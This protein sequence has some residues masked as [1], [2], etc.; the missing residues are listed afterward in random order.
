[1]IQAA[2]ACNKLDNLDSIPEMKN[3]LEE[4]SQTGGDLSFLRAIHVSGSKGKGSVCAFTENILKFKGLRTGMFTSPHL[5]HPRERIRVDGKPVCENVFAKHVLRLDSEMKAKG[6]GQISFFRFLWILAVDIFRE[7]GVEVGIIEVGMG[8]RF[9]ATNVIAHP[10]VCGITSLAMEHVNLLGP[11]IKEI[12]WNKAG[13]IKSG[14]P[15]LTVE[16]TDYLE[17]VQIIRNEA[18]K[19]G[20][21]LRVISSD[22]IDESVRLGIDG[23]HQ[24]GNAALASALAATWI[25]K[26]R[27]EMSLTPAEIGSALHLTRWPGRQQIVS[28]TDRVKI[29]LD[30]SHTFESVS[31]TAHWFSHHQ[32]S[33]RNNVLFFHCSPDRNY[34]KLLQPLLNISAIF[35]HAFFMIPKSVQGDLSKIKEHHQD[36]VNYW[37][38]ESKS[39]STASIVYEIPEETTNSTS[40]TNI[41][42]C[43]SLYLVGHF[44]SHF[45]IDSS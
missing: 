22:C 41:L 13:I 6:D 38:A 4:Y 23:S 8:G 19:R 11:T 7:A 2:L 3:L 14:V 45:E 36:M 35:S 27:P 16:Q 30:G 32:D 17:T 12:A 15:V 39:T 34:I 37:M 24:K 42:V 43:G 33:K 25:S 20:S 28:L 44:M 10:V 9:D 40:P 26:C 5:V 21:P 18:E 1:M 31:A 29:F